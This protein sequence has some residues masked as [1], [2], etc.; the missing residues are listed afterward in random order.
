M[1]RRIVCAAN[2]YPCGTVVLGARHFDALM[3]Q[4]I[5]LL[6]NLGHSLRAGQEEQGFIDQRGEFLIREEAKLVADKAGQIIRRV[7]GDEKRL[8]SE[9]LY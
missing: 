7:G 5:Q 1:E 6:K 4:Q 9:N 8:Y 3:H 2:R